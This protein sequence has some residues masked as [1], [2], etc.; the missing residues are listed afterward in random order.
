MAEYKGHFIFNK[1]SISLYASDKIGVYYMG[2]I[3]ALS[4]KLEVLY[5]GRAV[6][7]GVNIKSRLFDHFNNGEWID[8]SHF[9]YIE[10]LDINEAITFEKSEIVR[11]LYPKYNK[12]VG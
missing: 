2:C 12:R 10:F 8:V 9:G 3:N 4:G 11:L 5:I 1:L 7:S 6:G